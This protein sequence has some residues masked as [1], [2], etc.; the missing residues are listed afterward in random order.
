M[1][2]AL[3]QQEAAKLW[4]AEN[5]RRK[6]ERQNQK[7]ERR[8]CPAPFDFPAAAAPSVGRNQPCSCGSGRKFKK[9]LPAS[10]AWWWPWALTRKAT[11]RVLD[12][13]R[14]LPGNVI[15][16]VLHAQPRPKE[17]EPLWNARVEERQR[18]KFKQDEVRT[19]P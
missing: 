14:G 11:R 2:R 12:F 8:L 10:C 13:K 6:L 9:C 4:E 5:Q 15:G 16:T 1:F 3:A 19:G 18:C 17:R 7:E